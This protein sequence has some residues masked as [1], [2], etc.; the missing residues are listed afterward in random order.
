VGT[1]RGAPREET[2]DEESATTMSNPTDKHE[3]DRRDQLRRT[4]LAAHG[5][6]LPAADEDVTPAQARALDTAFDAMQAAGI[7]AKTSERHTS[8]WGIRKLLSAL[9]GRRAEKHRRYE[10]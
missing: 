1:I 6:A 9:R 7:Y 8:K 2:T 4:W 3:R 5:E 10:L